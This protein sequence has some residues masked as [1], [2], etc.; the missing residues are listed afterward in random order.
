M[1]SSIQL[2]RIGQEAPYRRQWPVTKLLK[3]NSSGYQT[4]NMFRIKV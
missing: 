1:I 4:W 3:N 2:Q